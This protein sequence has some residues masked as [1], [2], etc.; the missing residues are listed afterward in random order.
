MAP[1][2][3]DLQGSRDEPHEPHVPHAAAPSALLQL[4]LWVGKGRL[5]GKL[6]EKEAVKEGIF[7]SLSRKK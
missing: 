7:K 4:R 6:S 1:G 2:W 3:P 5:F